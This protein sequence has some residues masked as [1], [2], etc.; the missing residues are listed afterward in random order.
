MT[1]P[2]CISRDKEAWFE[3]LVGKAHSLEV[4]RRLAEEEAQ[5]Q[6]LERRAK[7][8]AKA[9]VRLHMHVG[10]MPAAGSRQGGEGKV[11]KGCAVQVYKQWLLVSVADLPTCM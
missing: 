11:C 2:E 7:I 1:Y 10:S 8:R 4:E 5:C 3:S 9:A 6:K